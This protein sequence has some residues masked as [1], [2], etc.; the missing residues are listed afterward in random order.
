[1]RGMSSNAHIYLRIQIMVVKIGENAY[2]LDTDEIRRVVNVPPECYHIVP[3]IM[4]NSR[5]QCICGIA[6]FDGRLVPVISMEQLLAE[7]EKIDYQKKERQ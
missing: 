2:G 1:M 4:Q 5:R 7:V 3:E 6:E